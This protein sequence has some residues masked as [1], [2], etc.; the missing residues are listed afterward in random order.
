TFNA[1]E[2]WDAMVQTAGDEKMS[3]ILPADHGDLPWPG[4]VTGVLIIGLYYWTTNQLVVQRTLG[5]KS[6][7]HGPWGSLLAGAIKLTFLFLFTLPGVMA[8]SRSPELHKPDTAYPTLVFVL[9]PGGLRGLILAA[10]IAASTSPVDS[11]LT[12]T[13]TI[14][15]MDFV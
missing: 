9:M 4:L 8:L 15:T 6:L 12:S 14:V 11:I 7:D 3:L 1:I 5:A 13:S 10:V 2:S